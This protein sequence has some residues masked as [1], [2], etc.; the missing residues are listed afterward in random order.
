MLYKI[1]RELLWGIRIKVN[2]PTFYA[3][4]T[5][6]LVLFINFPSLS[7]DQ[8]QQ[9]QQQQQLLVGYI[10]EKNPMLQKNGKIRKKTSLRG[11]I[12][13]KSIMKFAFR[14]IAKNIYLY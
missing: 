4:P 9:Q 7:S 10:E 5:I 13:V 1:S 8:Q 14:K 11:S 6:Y 2:R 12:R 3:S